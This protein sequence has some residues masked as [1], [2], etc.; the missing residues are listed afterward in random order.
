MTLSRHLREYWRDARAVFQRREPDMP[1]KHTRSTDNVL[2]DLGFPDAEELSAK[3]I[4]AMK[5]NAILGRRGLTQRQA[6]VRLGMPQP[7][8]SALKRYK[9]RG[10][11]L[12]RL[13]HALVALDQSVEI[14]VRPRA[15]TKREPGI[16]VAA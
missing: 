5:V 4:L 8:I 10:I 11:S 16:K 1:R 15:R 7:K 13:M 6:A 12:E 9:L 14:S 3:T 2:I